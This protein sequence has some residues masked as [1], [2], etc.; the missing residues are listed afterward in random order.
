[1]LPFVLGAAFL[2]AR[3][4]PLLGWMAIVHITAHSLFSHKKMRFLY[5]AMP[6]LIILS[7]LGTCHIL[8]RFAAFATAT[9]VMQA[10]AC[11]VLTGISV[12]GA[13]NPGFANNWIS[14]R[15]GQSSM[16][17]LRDRTDLCSLALATHF[18]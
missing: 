16:A 18:S 1:M 9:Q 3:R 8:S 17:W 12:A 15:G 11:I 6:T 13:P 14:N 10:G 4:A 7:G 2:G 5:P